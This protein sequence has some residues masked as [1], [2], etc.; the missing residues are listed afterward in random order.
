MALPA[1]H[2]GRGYSPFHKTF[3]EKFPEANVDPVRIDDPPTG[4]STTNISVSDRQP[5]PEKFATS[6]F[7]TTD[8][9]KKAQEQLIGQL[10]MIPA[11]QC[12]KAPWE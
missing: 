10:N 3:I 6:G 1:K 5:E 8:L 7:L 9:P 12:T 11:K 4:G 2:Q